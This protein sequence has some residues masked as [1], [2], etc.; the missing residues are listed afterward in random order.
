M[1]KKVLVVD[2]DEI[3]LFLHDLVIKQ[4]GFADETKTFSNGQLALQYLNEQSAHYE[5][6]IIFLDINMPVMNGWQL[7]SALEKTDY[8]DQVIVIIVSSSI[9]PYDLAQSKVYPMVKS[10]LPKPLSE[11][12]CIALKRSL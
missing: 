4:S 11:Q 6:Y 7:L 3:V 5:H 9:D 1:N 2:D 12:A 8:K 10:Y